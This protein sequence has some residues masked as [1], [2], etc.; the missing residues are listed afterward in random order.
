[1]SE[2]GEQGTG[3]GERG[4][5]D[6]PDVQRWVVLHCGGFFS[7]LKIKCRESV[8]VTLYALSNPDILVRV[9]DTKGW[10]STVVSPPG[11]GEIVFDNLCPKCAKKIFPREVLETAT[12]LRKERMKKGENDE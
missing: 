6:G 4:T 2:D 12:R 1:M 11:A 10:F 7:H 5:E 8:Q 9:L 3:D